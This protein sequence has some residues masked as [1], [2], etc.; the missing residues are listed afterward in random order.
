MS[1]TYARALRFKKSSPLA[2]LCRMLR[3]ILRNWPTARLL[4]GRGG[5]GA[6][7][8]A[9]TLI[10]IRWT[11]DLTPADLRDCLALFATWLAADSERLVGEPVEGSDG[12]SVMASEQRF[13]SSGRLG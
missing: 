8:D 11:G 9:N 10:Y 6:Q 7:L 5:F 13:Y 4:H 3:S 2:R 12:V 1:D